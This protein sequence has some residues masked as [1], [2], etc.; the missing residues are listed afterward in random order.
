M[1]VLTHV[2]YVRI[3]KMCNHNILLSCISKG[4]YARGKLLQTRSASGCM[5][6]VLYKYTQMHFHCE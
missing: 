5:F 4:S 3:H 6:I 1:L 2:E